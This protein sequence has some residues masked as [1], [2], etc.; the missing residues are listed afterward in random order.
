[1]EQELKRE[2]NRSYIVEHWTRVLSVAVLVVTGFYIHWPFMGGGPESFI[3][4]NMR[5]LH[6]VFAYVLILGLIIRL[7]MAVF[8]RFDA[9]CW[10]FLTIGNITNLPDIAG[11]YL[12]LKSSH[13]DYRKYNPLQ[14]LA[15]LAMAVCIVIMALTGCAIYHGNLFGVIPCPAGFTWVNGIMGGEPN[16]RLV[17]LA[18]T[19]FFIIF[20]VIHVYMS[21][22]IT[23]VNKDRSM[24]SI[25]TGYKL[26]KTHHP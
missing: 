4:A 11:Y 26:V 3:M 9:D 15:Y 10:D 14:A 18:I 25:F 13:K 17:H 5:F 19:W 12:F 6:F 22:M 8:S 21:L 16:T 7:Y 1:M 23:A 20:T 2:W 24:S